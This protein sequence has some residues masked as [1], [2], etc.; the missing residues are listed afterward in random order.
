MADTESVTTL[1]AMYRGKLYEHRT[2][3]IHS[4]CTLTMLK[5]DHVGWKRN[6][7]NS[8]LCFI[9]FGECLENNIKHRF[10]EDVAIKIW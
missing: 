10:G 4:D 2:A 7:V 9:Q 3:R 1:P 8:R 6:T 5:N